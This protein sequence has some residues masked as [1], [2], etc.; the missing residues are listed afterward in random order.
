M[1]SLCSDVIYALRGRT[2]ATAESCTGGGIGQLLTSVPGS[3]AVFKGGVISYSSLVK[4]EL[5]GVS[6]RDL[7]EFGAVSAPVAKSMAFGVRKLLKADVAVSSTGLAGPEGDGSGKK[8]GTVFIGYCD[9]DR[10]IA[11]EFH[12]SG[13]REAVRSQAAQAALDLILE[14]EKAAG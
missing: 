1:M 11:R 4:V 10:C 3:S 13:D 12:F 14:M 7:K 2:L 8:V 6:P 9:K 5:L